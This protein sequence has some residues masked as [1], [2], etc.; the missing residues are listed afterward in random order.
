M[1]VEFFADALYAP[2]RISCEDQEKQAMIEA[3]IRDAE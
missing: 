2:M 1:A 3:G